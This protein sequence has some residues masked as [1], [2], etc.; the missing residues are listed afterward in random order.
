M[1]I[2]KKY[3]NPG[4]EEDYYDHDSDRKS[5]GAPFVMRTLFQVID[6]SL[7]DHNSLLLCMLVE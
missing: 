3:Y 5:D 7:K 2:S 4:H 1:Q 6:M